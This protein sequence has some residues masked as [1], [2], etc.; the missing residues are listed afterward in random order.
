M[1]QLPIG[2]A[3]QLQDFM[4]RRLWE[5]VGVGVDVDVVEVDRREAV[6]VVGEMFLASLLIVMSDGK[7]AEMWRSSSEGF[8]YQLSMCC[9]GGHLL[10]AL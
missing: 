2:V 8:W 6:M 1:E 3:V 7:N 4:F 5:L 10:A 9:D